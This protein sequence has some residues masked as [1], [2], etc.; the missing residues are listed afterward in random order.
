MKK[1]LIK[2]RTSILA[3]ALIVLTIS[4]AYGANPEN[5]EVNEACFDNWQYFVTSQLSFNEFSEYWKDLFDRYSKN[6]C[7]YND[8]NQLTKQLDAVSKQIKDAFLKCNAAQALTLEKKYNEI[9]AELFYVRNFIDIPVSEIQTIPD[10]KVYNL[11]RS[12]FVLD[13]Q[14]FTEEELKTIFDKFKTKYKDKIGTRYGQCKD[15]DFEELKKKWDSFIKNIKSLGDQAKSVKDNWGKAISTP[16]TA[17][18]GFVKGIE[19][20]R[21]NNLPAIKTPDQVV[22]EIYKEYEK[23]GA[24]EPTIV[25][26][27]TKIIDTSEE[28]NRKVDSASVRAEYEA[29]YKKGN[30]AVASE[31][32]K[33]IQEILD[34][35]NA[36][37]EPLSK[38]KTCTK[39]GGERQCQ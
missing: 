10:E 26:I 34:I 25:D 11:M 23:T 24:G 5:L 32:D 39:K 9:K 29:K 16:S 35:V 37:F 19:N 20:M 8:I 13:N 14:N 38:L 33:K 7:H 21:L 28:Y 4:P 15:A 18:E 22:T 36:T 6:I 31:Y 2:I 3:I 12:E 1:L 27:Q 30:D 17:M